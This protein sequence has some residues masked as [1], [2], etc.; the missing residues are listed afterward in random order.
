MGGIPRELP[1][2]SGK[3]ISC[4]M[5]LYPMAVFILTIVWTIRWW[6]RLFMRKMIA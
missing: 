2:D 1:E 4:E 5:L 3:V 6:S